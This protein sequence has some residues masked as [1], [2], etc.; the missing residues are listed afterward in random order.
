MTFQESC[1]VVE[2][3]EMGRAK[4]LLSRLGNHFGSAGASPSLK[5][6]T[7]QKFSSLIYENPCLRIVCVQQWRR[8]PFFQMREGI[9]SWIHST[10]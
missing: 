2:E 8:R 9:Q 6:V 7:L 1:K 3:C 5:F 4:L 10:A